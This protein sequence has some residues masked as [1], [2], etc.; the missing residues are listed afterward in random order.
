MSKILVIDD[1][2]GMRKMLRESPGA[3]GY[4]VG[5][6]GDGHDRAWSIGSQ[7]AKPP[8]AQVPRDEGPGRLPAPGTVGREDESRHEIV[9]MRSAHDQTTL[10]Q[11]HGLTETPE[12]WVVT[13]HLSLER[14]V[15]RARAAPGSH[16]ALVR[17]QSDCD[18]PVVDRQVPTAP[19]AGLLVGSR[20]LR[21]PRP[22][23][24]G[25]ACEGVY[26]T[27]PLS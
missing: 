26:E 14:P 6:A 12:Q 19:R 18:E 24:V 8:V 20:E 10:T 23:A 15:P 17:G 2:D 9:G 22:G 1:N 11:G 21:F 16:G 13:G 27:G 25:V 3:L 4:E 5:V 7:G